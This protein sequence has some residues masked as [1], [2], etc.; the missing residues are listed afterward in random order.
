MNLTA[1]LADTGVSRW[2][3]HSA[4]TRLHGF[5]STQNA[6]QALAAYLIALQRNWERPPWRPNRESASN[7]VDAARII[8]S[9]D[10]RLA[11]RPAWLPMQRH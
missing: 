11:R 2:L 7:V 5:G 1:L 4:A 8:P 3:V 9:T 6:A 10:R